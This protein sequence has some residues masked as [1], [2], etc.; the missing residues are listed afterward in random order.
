MRIQWHLNLTHL[1]FSISVTQIHLL[2]NTSHFIPFLDK[3]SLLDTPSSCFIHFSSLH[4]ASPK[5]STS[6][7]RALG[8]H[9]RR[10]DNLNNLSIA[11]NMVEPRPLRRIAR[12]ISACSSLPS[13]IQG[14]GWLLYEHLR[15]I[16]L[17]E[18]K[19]SWNGPIDVCGSK[20]IFTQ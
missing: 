9:P 17:Y 13:M 14:R 10:A 2:W 11:Y 1:G 4:R 3:V 5:I 19:Y 20:L 12:A 8:V 16:A 6:L 18:M 7:R 15:F